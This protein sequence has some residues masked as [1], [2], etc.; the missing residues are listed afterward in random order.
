MG[1]WVCVFTFLFPVPSGHTR[2]SS[3]VTEDSFLRAFSGDGVVCEGENRCP[4]C[5]VCLYISLWLWWISAGGGESA[6]NITYTCNKQL[7]CV[8]VCVAH[9]CLRFG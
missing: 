8:G 7:W 1:G 5:P 9:N 3:S 4:P 2:G 6:S